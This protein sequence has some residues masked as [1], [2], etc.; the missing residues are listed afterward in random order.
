MVH[1]NS[2]AKAAAAAELLRQAYRIADA[3]PADR[4]VIYG[5]LTAD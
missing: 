5:R 2:E 3:R 1:A 4:P